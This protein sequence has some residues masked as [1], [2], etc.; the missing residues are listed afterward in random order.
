[1]HVN[2]HHSVNG[3]PSAPCPP[4]QCDR[5][6]WPAWAQLL[7]SLAVLFHLCALVAACLGAPPSSWVE[8]RAYETFRP[9]C[10]LT[11]QG[12]A[13]RYYSRLDTTVD[14][15][16][17]RPWGTPILLAEMESKDQ[18]GTT[19]RRTLRL[20]DAEPVWPRLRHQRRIDLAFHLAADPRWAASYA[21][22]IC[23]SYGCERVSLSVQ[24][25]YIPDL[26]RLHNADGA[27]TASLLEPDDG[28]TYG[29][30]IKLGEFRCTD[31]PSP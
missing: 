27:L 21:R 15:A 11:F 1:M 5:C 28:S 12:V 24:A 26:S 29:P 19:L 31:F 6:P 25:H 9:Y 18:D 7:A 30:R 17:P 2:G 3:D 8:S 14:P 20:P 10:D 23:K 4:S 22:H 13:Y 16:N